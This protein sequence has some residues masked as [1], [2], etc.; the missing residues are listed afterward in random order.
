MTR[1]ARSPKKAGDPV[2]ALAAGAFV[3]GLASWYFGASSAIDRTI[4]LKSFWIAACALGALAAAGSL[5]LERSL[6]KAA[7]G[8][9]AFAGIAVL[10]VAFNFIALA[11]VHADG[12]RARIEGATFVAYAQPS[13]GPRMARFV[14]RYRAVSLQAVHASACVDDTPVELELRDGALGEAW[15]ERV[16]C[17]DAR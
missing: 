13:K 6:R 3:V 7:L 11:N 10:F 1:M 17:T 15:I 14:W 12:S 8:N 5:V 16:R 9:A 4:E 2:Q